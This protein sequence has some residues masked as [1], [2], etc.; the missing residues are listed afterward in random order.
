MN[1]S[2][3]QY[4][5]NR[6]AEWR[7]MTHAWKREV[8]EQNHAEAL[9]ENARRSFGMANQA[10]PSKAKCRELIA[11]LEAYLPGRVVAMPMWIDGLWSDYWYV[12]LDGQD[13]GD[14]VYD[15]F[16]PKIKGDIL[17][18]LVYR[19]SRAAEIK[20]ERAEVAEVEP[21]LLEWDE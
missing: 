2:P 6:R 4:F 16:G 19:A 20:A 11:Q 14:I 21:L 13:A 18:R 8:I 5:G 9:A 12:T 7:D 17:G 1:T 15:S 10:E 3:G